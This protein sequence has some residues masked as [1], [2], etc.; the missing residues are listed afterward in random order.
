MYI[1]GAIKKDGVCC[2]TCA[3]PYTTVSTILPAFIT[4][5]IAV[6]RPMINAAVSIFLHPLM[7][8][9]DISDGDLLS[10]TPTTTARP[11]NTEAISSI[12]QPRLTQPYTIIA[13]AMIR[14]ATIKNLRT[15]SAPKS[16]ML[17][18]FCSF[19]ISSSY[20]GLSSGFLRIF[21][22]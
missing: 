1:A 8:I 3:R 14:E 6:A 15:V 7:K 13:M 19:C 2:N 16:S 17:W 5:A 20:I 9:V 22:A 21:N 10:I 11:I 18:F 12:S 4:F